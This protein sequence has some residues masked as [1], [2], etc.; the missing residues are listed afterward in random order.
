MPSPKSAQT[1]ERFSRQR[2]R[3][4]APEIELRRALHRRG[5][6]YRVDRAPI[7]GMRS[8]A[9]IVFGP[10]RVAVFVD[11]CFWHGCPVHST[12][13]SHNA[14][15]WHEKIA[16]NRRRDARV[17]AAL[18]AEGWVVVRVWEHEDAE[19]AAS[20]IAQLIRQRRPCPELAKEAGPSQ[21]S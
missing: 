20:R 15:W 6:R 4:T 5:L 14:V 2:Q 1:S 8:R 12:K 21:H 17:S 16:A 9:D 19:T 13:P 11:G 18:A 10:S 7:P 3:D